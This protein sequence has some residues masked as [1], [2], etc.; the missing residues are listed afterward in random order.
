[1]IIDRETG[2]P[3]P[4]KFQFDVSFH[5]RRISDVRFPV[6]SNAFSRIAEVSRANEAL[7]LKWGRPLVRSLVSP[8]AAE[9]IKWLGHARASRAAY[10]D[11]VN[12]MMK[13]FEGLAAIVKRN[14]R[15]VDPSN[16]FL[17][18]ERR[19]SDSM[20]TALDAYRRGRD[21]SSELLFRL[22]YHT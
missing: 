11:R 21:N 4:E 2:E 7:Y 14:R 19:F 16:T 17:Y 10:S 1:M 8:L 5:E 18:A 9:P 15:P 3:D 20:V 12:P 6:R 13:A 22:M